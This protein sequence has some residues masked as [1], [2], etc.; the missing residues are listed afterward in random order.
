MS[1]AKKRT[2]ER[3]AKGVRLAFDAMIKRSS[4]VGEVGTPWQTL[5][6]EEREERRLHREASGPRGRNS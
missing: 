5:I 2:A 4:A 3:L 6:A 1:V